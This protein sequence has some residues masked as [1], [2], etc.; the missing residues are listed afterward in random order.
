MASTTTQA[1]VSIHPLDPLSAAEIERAWEIVR[2]EHAP[3]PRIRVVFIML[4]EPAKK[5][6]L[7]HRPGDRGGAGRLRRAGR[8]RD[9]EDLRGGGLADRGPRAVLGARARRAAGHR[10]GR[11]RRVRGGGARRP[12]L[13]G[14]HAQARDH[15]LQP[16]HGGPVVGGQLRL[17]GGRR[18]PARPRADLGAAGPDGQRLRPAGRQP[19]H[20]RGPERDEG[21]RGRGRRRRAAAAGRRQLLAGRRR[22]TRSGL[23]PIEIRQPEGPSFELRGP[24]AALAEVADAHRLHARARAWCSTP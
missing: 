24:R 17:P 9:G 23:K 18:P 6:V 10:A 22:A 1:T 3:G 4:H 15:R 2:T 19:G 14:G 8:L 21:A 16:G 5:V 7:E 20:R 11:V 13:A 12:A